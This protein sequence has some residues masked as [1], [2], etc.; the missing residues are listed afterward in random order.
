MDKYSQLHSGEYYDP[1]SNE[2]GLRKEQLERSKLLYQYNQSHPS[3]T[4]LR[5]QLLKEMFLE[6]GENC[7]IEQPFYANWA[8]KFVR[9]GKNIYANF[10]LTLVDDTYI[11]VG[12]YTQF[13]PNVTLTTAS[14]PTDPKEREQGYQFNKP[15][16]IGRNCWI[17]AGAIILA[18]ITIG[19]NTVIGAGSIVT[20]DIPS[21]AIAVGNPCKV[22]KTT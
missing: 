16:T 17:G 18:G 12:D 10:N 21:N 3:E 22:I 19:D 7:Y 8:C 14:H 4:K 5:E 11:T 2:A 9:F 6:I 15:I 1:I 20:K 13:G